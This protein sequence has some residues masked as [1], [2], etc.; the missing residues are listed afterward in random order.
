VVIVVVVVMIVVA[1][2]AA[3]HF[4]EL[5]ASFVGLLALL[6]MALHRVA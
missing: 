4:F 5:L 6:P 1:I 2:A 3:A